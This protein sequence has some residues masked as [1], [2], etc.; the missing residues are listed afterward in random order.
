MII[1]DAPTLGWN[2]SRVWW[3]PVLDFVSRPDSWHGDRLCPP[4]DTFN[5][6][7]FIDPS[8]GVA[9]LVD[10]FVFTQRVERFVARHFGTSRPA[11]VFSAGVIA[12][13]HINARRAE[14]GAAPNGGPATQPGN[15]GVTEGPPS[16]S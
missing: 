4:E 7:R 2:V 9:K 3:S 16:V 1:V 14:P 15:S 6:K 12:E 13:E 8:A 5:Y 10:S 11:F